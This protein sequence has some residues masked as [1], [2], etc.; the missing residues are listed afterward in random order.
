MKSIFAKKPPFPPIKSDLVILSKEELEA[1]I[2][3]T[4]NYTYRTILRL[5]FGSGLKMTEI[6]N[7]KIEDLDFETFRIFVN[8]TGQDNTIKFFPETLADEL[9]FLTNY[10][11]PDNYVFISQRGKKL[12]REGIYKLFK[13]CLQKADIQKPATFQSLRDS[14]AVNLLQSGIG[15]EHVHKL[16]G[17]QDLR[18]TKKYL[19]LVDPAKITIVGLN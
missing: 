18:H 10:R 13:R 4:E 7:L 15:I 2:N 3:Q 6:I 17:N 16:L 14:F 19:R 11:P 9:S 1:I 8:K 12:T 5:A